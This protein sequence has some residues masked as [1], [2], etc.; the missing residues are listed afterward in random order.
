[1]ASTTSGKG[2]VHRSM[3]M[4]AAALAM[5]LALV[6]GCSGSNTA[7]SAPASSSSSVTATV[8]A[9]GGTVTGPD[10]VQVVI[11]AGALTADTTIGIARTSAGAPATLPDGSLPAGGIYEFTPHDLVFKKPVTIR[12]PIPSNAV[13][14]EV[15]MASLG[16][17]WQIN[18]ATVNGGFA[19]WERNSFS[20]GM[21]P[22]CVIPN[23]NTDLYPCVYPKGY[24]MAT[25]IPTTAITRQ[26]F[27]FL[28]TDIGSA[29]S[30]VVNGAGALTLTLNYQA[31]PDCIVPGLDGARA[32]LLRWNP[33]VPVN[34]PN[35]GLQTLFDGPV[36]LVLTTFPIFGGGSYDRLVGSTPV[37]VPSSA[38]TDATNAFGFTFS[39]QRPGKSRHTGG[40]F[41]TIIGPMAAPGTTYNVG[42]TI[43]GLTGTV[44]LQ[45]NG[46]NSQTVTAPN[47]SFVFT[48]IAAGSSYDV[49]V[50][51]QP[52]GQTCTVP[53][54][55]GVNLQANVT[56]VT[57]SC[58]AVSGPVPLAATSIAAG[59]WNSL[60]VATDGT[61]WAWGN[62]VDPTT[63]GYKA[64][65]PFA[66]TPVQV[67]GLTG[68]RTVALSSESGAFY[69][70]HT[71]GT[72]SAWGRNDVGQLG[73]RTTTT[74]LIP[75]KVLQDATTPMDEVC[76]IAAGS[77]VLLMARETGCSPGQRSINYGPWIVGLFIG[78]NFGGESAAGFSGNGAIAKLATGW[79]V[80][81]TGS[82]TAS[83]MT[84]PDAANTG[85]AITI[86]TGRGDGYIWGANGGNRLGA[87]GSV[88]FAGGSAGLVLGGWSGLYP[89]EMGRDFAIAV[90]E[91]GT[92]ESVGRNVEGQLGDGTTNYRT[93]MAPVLGLPAFPVTAYS[94]GQVSAAA[95]VN[96]QLWAWGTLGFG[97][98]YQYFQP[99]QLGTGTGFTQVSVGDA[100]GLAIGPG[101]EVYS[102]GEST[103]GGLGRIGSG[104]LPAVVMRP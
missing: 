11:P 8:G 81:Q 26:T 10:G 20:F 92:L 40:D 6:A 62:N 36:G 75:V 95:I 94:A 91:T 88:L 42:G 45:N 89:V 38:L 32:K 97:P 99:R 55:T 19:E 76:R 69:A 79:P 93:T 54:G 74:R 28:G 63:G 68:V 65:A 67:Q 70:L 82:Q 14:S 66:T 84:V 22:L 72:V 13:G 24:A 52:A 30:W 15:F 98:V 59:F 78:Q 7:T 43:S 25:A 61:V 77:N 1:M 102:W 90:D 41:I 80:G 29:G 9:G 101:G 96:G 104:S 5:M 49:R 27:G 71:D 17:E 16:A 50:L 48:S 73:D 34:S 37:V 2:N 31:A 85:G 46:G 23:G 3:G 64:A 53:N 100:H 58:T 12:I 57:V 56:G 47:N 18:D 4:R 33:D 35:R 103:N 60:A 87:G 39:C 44:V 21:V 83:V 86:R 51:T